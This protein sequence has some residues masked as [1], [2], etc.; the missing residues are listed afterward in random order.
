MTLPSTHHP[1]HG[2]GRV[3][4]YA[5]LV[6]E[7]FL[8]LQ[9]S[10]L[11]GSEC[12]IAGQALSAQAEA[13][14]LQPGHDQGLERLLPRV[15]GLLQTA[16]LEVVEAVVAW[17]AR[18]A[19]ATGGGGG[20][21]ARAGFVY[22]GEDYLMRV[23][24]DLTELE[25][26][27]FVRTYLSK[28]VSPCANPFAPAR[29]YHAADPLPPAT[30]DPLRVRMAATVLKRVWSRSTVDLLR[31]SLISPGEPEFASPHCPS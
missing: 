16:T 2:S 20:A 31:A 15:W 12:C 24:S 11:S 1:H 13:N 8:Q 6:Q 3:N 21:G 9:R 5:S 18:R 27:L 29:A 19:A 17:Q 30:V 28:G 10:G 26:S 25:G 14:G 23:G 7:Y 22:G 4:A